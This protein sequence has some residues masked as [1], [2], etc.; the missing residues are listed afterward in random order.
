MN[1]S[2]SMTVDY[3][4]LLV[5][6]LTNQNP[7]E[8]MDTNDM[9]AQLAEFSQLTELEE[10]NSAFSDTLGM[11]QQNYA[12]SL[13]GQEVS[14]SSTDENDNTTTG[15]GTVTQIGIDNDVVSLLVGG[16]EIGLN[17]ILSIGAS[18]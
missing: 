9:S 1:D 10:M 4:K 8:P 3:M 16:M 6:Q 13:L 18:Q 14:Y 12:S 7:M 5:T 17:D 2:S 11:L 15:T